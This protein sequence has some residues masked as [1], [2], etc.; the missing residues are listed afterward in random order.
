VLALM[1]DAT[2]AGLI[3]LKNSAADC[4]PADAAKT[5]PFAKPIPGVARL[6][7]IPVAEKC[8]FREHSVSIQGTFSVHSASVQGTFRSVGWKWRQSGPVDALKCSR[9][10]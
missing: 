2:N 8:P 1:L 9:R 10:L 6:K 7:V 5:P 4:S 3:N